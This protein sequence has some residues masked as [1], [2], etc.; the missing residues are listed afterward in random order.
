MSATA[1]GNLF[2]IVVQIIDM[3]DM[4]CCE[5]SAGFPDRQPISRV[6]SS[7]VSGIT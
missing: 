4:E 2:A 5:H 3:H 1:G 6:V 7:F